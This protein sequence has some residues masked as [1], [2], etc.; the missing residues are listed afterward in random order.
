MK[1]DQFEIV[2]L[3][4]KCLSQFGYFVKSGNDCA[5]IDPLRDT[6]QV[7][8]LIQASGCALKYIILTHFHADFVAGHFDLR[9][10]YGSSVYMGPTEEALPNVTA[11]AL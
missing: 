8:E 9:N 4:T 11:R 10:K 1:S 6:Q 2:Q 7:E 5:V 3:E